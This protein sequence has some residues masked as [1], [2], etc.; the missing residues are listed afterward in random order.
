MGF[1]V[2]VVPTA[3]HPII[4][5]ERGGDPAWPH[6]II[7]GHYDVQ[8]AD[9]LALWQTPRSSRRSAATA[10]TGGR[11]GQQGPLLANIAAVAGL[12]EKHP[13]LPCASPS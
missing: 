12:L 5:A 1:A 13:R 10:C 8:P 11:G 4:L 9:P 2:E 6:V 3:R 7:Y